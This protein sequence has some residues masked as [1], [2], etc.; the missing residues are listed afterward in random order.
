LIERAR[1]ALAGAPT[2]KQDAPAVARPP[3]PFLHVLAEILGGNGPSRTQ[4]V[5][6]GRVYQLRVEKSPDAKAARAFCELGLITSTAAVARI[7]GLLWR[8]DGG[9]PV[10]FRLWIEDDIRHPL[11]LR[12]EYQP[13][14]Y[15]RLTFEAEA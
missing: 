14:T 7:S 3:R 1:Q 9:K 8:D 11:P 6:N 15:L 4:Y 5:Y 10:E 12:I 2:R 13:K